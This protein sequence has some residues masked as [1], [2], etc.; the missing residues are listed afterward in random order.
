MAH[1]FAES[2]PLNRVECSQNQGYRAVETEME[3]A[4]NENT[5]VDIPSS[6]ID[7]RPSSTSTVVLRGGRFP[8]IGRGRQKKDSVS[9]GTFP[10]AK[11]EGVN[12]YSLYVSCDNDS[13]N[14]VEKK[15]K[16]S[17]FFVIFT[18]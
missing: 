4:T 18:P 3:R 11:Y 10:T 7:I 6:Q 12:K 8:L 2:V 9:P 13:S 14:S 1:I 15:K 5:N 17:F 16:V